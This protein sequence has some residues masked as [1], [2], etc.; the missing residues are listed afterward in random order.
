MKEKDLGELTET[1]LR[2]LNEIKKHEKGIYFE[3][4]VTLAIKGG[5]DS[6]G[7]SDWLFKQNCIEFKGNLTFIT[8]HGSER[9]RSP[10]I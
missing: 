10:R 2:V 8:G 4:A 5:F 1:D 3:D 6:R 7:I 9:L